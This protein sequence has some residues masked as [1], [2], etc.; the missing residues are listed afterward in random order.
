MGEAERVFLS[1]GI[2]RLDS[3]APAIASSMIIKRFSFSIRRSTFLGYIFLPHGCG[4]G[5]ASNEITKE[6]SKPGICEEQVMSY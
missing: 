5:P 6:A 3:S 2:L 4:N 1:S